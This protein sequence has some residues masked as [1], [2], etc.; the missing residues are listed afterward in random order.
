MQMLLIDAFQEA[1][2]EAEILLTRKIH[3]DIRS[4]TAAAYFAIVQQHQYSIFYLLSSY[5]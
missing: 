5:Y 2:S 3:S 4:K 1:N